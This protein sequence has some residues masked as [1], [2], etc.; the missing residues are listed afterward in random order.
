MPKPRSTKN[1]PASHAI[2]IQE[3]KELESQP[4]CHR[5]AAQQLVNNCHLIDSQDES[6]VFQN[7]GRI[8]RDFID[9]YAASLAICDLM[10]GSFVIP[11]GC[12]KFKESALSILPRPETPRLHVST[13]EI[14][15][16]LEGLARSDSAWNTWVSYRHKAAR[17]CDASRAENE[18][19]MSLETA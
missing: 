18:K 4:L 3:L 19:G 14:D 13:Q 1:L 15:R 8:A 2:A 17:F 11:A 10:R 5:I 9:S 16:C 6:A 7:S 12:D